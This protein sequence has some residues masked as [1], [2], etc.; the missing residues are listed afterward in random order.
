MVGDWSISALP[1]TPDECTR[2][3][4]NRP[5]G[6]PEMAGRTALGTTTLV[7]QNVLHPAV[8]GGFL[9]PRH[10]RPVRTESHRLAAGTN[11]ERAAHYVDLVWLGRV[12]LQ[13][14]LRRGC[15]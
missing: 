5:S 9:S 12:A 6:K 2:R 1:V 11:L 15:L 14:G 3:T 4:G 10:A 7:V 13:Y 8:L